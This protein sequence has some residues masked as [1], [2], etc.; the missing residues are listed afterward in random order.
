M[1]PNEVKPFKI[2]NNQIIPT[3]GKPAIIDFSATWCPPCQKLKPIF[4]KLEEDFHDRINFITIDVDENQELAQSYG[5]Q[6]IPYLVFVNNDGQIQN[7][8]VGFQDRDQ[9]LASINTYF[10]F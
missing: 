4:N 2:E 5:V 9:L 3:N 8:I 10:G 1:A 7:T 6:N